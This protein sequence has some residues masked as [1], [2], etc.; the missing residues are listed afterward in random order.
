[1]LE[2]KLLPSFNF[3]EGYYPV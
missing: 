1:M 2:M 3:L